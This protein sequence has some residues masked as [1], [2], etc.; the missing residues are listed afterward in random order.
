MHLS[1][2]T[3]YICNGKGFR[4]KGAWHIDFLMSFICPAFEAG[5]FYEN[6]VAYKWFF[7]EV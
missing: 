1:Q 3:Y 5:F 2:K 4:I 6:F 7:Q